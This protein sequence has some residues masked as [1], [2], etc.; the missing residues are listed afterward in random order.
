MPYLNSSKVSLREKTEEKSVSRHTEGRA[1]LWRQEKTGPRSQIQK[2]IMPC[3]KL[4]CHRFTQLQPQMFRLQS[5]VCPEENAA[6]WRWVPR[7]DT[8]PWPRAPWP[9]C[10][11]HPQD[12]GPTFQ[13]LLNWTEGQNTGTSSRT[14]GDAGLL[15]ATQT[16]QRT[17]PE[18]RV[19]RPQSRGQRRGTGWL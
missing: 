13:V 16:A 1:C 7:N 15:A 3:T 18:D 10:Q 17:V 5:T 14:P 2:Q 9:G 12:T 4:G 19:G 6:N 11:E 8:A